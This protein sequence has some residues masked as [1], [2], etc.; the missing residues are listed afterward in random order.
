M[1]YNMKCNPSFTFSRNET[2]TEPTEEET[3][4]NDDLTDKDYVKESNGTTKIVNNDNYEGEIRAEIASNELERNKNERK[5][6]C[7]DDAIIHVDAAVIENDKVIDP[8]RNV[9]EDAKTDNYGEITKIEETE[10]LKNGTRSKDDSRDLT[11][12]RAEEDEQFEGKLSKMEEWTD[13]AAG[14]PV[15]LVTNWRSNME[16][17]PKIVA[18]QLDKSLS[19]LRKA[20]RM[21]VELETYPEE[22]FHYPTMMEDKFQN[23]TGSKD[24]V[25]NLSGMEDNFRNLTER[26]EDSQAEAIE[27]SHVDHR[28]KLSRMDDSRPFVDKEILLTVH[29]VNH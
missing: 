3:S 17:D 19:S 27:R 18:N 22:E 29:K 1:C 21:E 10:T 4:E 7:S 26:E 2:T 23:F 12:P 5:D 25:H 15:R 14:N 11:T 9:T 13:A 28:Q 24:E 16:D 20:S 6:N 8:K